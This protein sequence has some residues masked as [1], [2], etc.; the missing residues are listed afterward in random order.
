MA[1]HDSDLES[2]KT[3]PHSIEAE[4]AVLGGLLLEPRVWEDV[5]TLVVADDFYTPAH[6]LIFEAVVDLTKFDQPLDAVTL[7]ETLK[8]HDTLDDSGGAA[9]IMEIVEE[10][11]GASN[12]KAYAQIVQERSVLRNMIATARNIAD[13]AYRPQGRQ[14][15]QILEEAEQQILQIAENRPGVGEAVSVDR[16]LEQAIAKVEELFKTEG[17]ITGVSTG[18]KDLDEKTAGM[19]KSDLVIVAGRPSMGKTTFAMNLVEAAFMRDVPAVVFSMEMP[20]DQIVMR[21]MASLGRINQGKLRT[22]DL[23][24]EDWDRLTTAVRLMQGKPLYIDD[25]PALTPTDMRSRARRVDRQV[26][27]KFGRGVGMVMVDY[28]QLMRVAGG[29]ENRATEISEISRSLKALAKEL[30]CPVIAL[31]QLN[32]SLEQRPNKR[33]VMSDLRECVTGDTLVMLADGRR[34]PI[35]SLVGQ[36]P[37]VLS[38]TECGQIEFSRADKVWPVGEKSVHRVTLRSGRQIRCTQK[39]RLLTATGWKTLGGIAVGERLALARSIPE[40]VDT[41]GMAEHALIFLGHMI[42]HGHYVERQSM[43]YA[44]ANEVNGDA[45][46]LA[47]EAFGCSV[48]RRG[49]QGI[50]HQ[51]ELSGSGGTSHPEDAGQFLTT[52]G[53]FGQEAHTK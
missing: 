20:S 2:I 8:R 11:P 19:Q 40:P 45:L 48:S 5:S 13:S 46:R 22:G 24:P 36:S 47:A 15:S 16:I 42:G 53:V 21:L 26:R 37:D 52:M 35:Q 44:A 28:L 33:P 23:Q 9:Y 50:G 18:F 31:S 6:R 17:T 38:K 30:E 34:V 12:V 29:G 27:Q 25:T 14:A 49:S 39:H 10:T 7:I 1:Q 41:L 4:R 32:R 3:P 51:L 43:R